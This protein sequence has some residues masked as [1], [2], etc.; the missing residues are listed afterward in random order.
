MESETEEEKKYSSEMEM[1]D[2]DTKKVGVRRRSEKNP[3]A[4]P[5]AVATL[6][7]SISHNAIRNDIL[8]PLLDLTNPGSSSNRWRRK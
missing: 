3:T 1:G 8:S 5:G 7:P 4:Q 2:R 6:P